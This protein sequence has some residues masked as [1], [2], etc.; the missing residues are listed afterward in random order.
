MVETPNFSLPLSKYSSVSA[1]S[2][3]S[4]N[5]TSPLQSAFS[6]TLWT[7][8]Q[9]YSEEVYKL[10]CAS[11]V[12]PLTLHELEQ[13]VFHS[14]QIVR[15]A[16][17]LMETQSA[18]RVEPI[19]NSVV[20]NVSDRIA[21]AS[22]TKPSASSSTTYA[23]NGIICP[24]K[25]A[26]VTI[27]SPLPKINSSSIVI[28]KPVHYSLFHSYQQRLSS[29]SLPEPAQSPPAST[30]CHIP[31]TV[32]STAV[33]SVEVIVTESA[34]ITN[35]DS[36]NSLVSNEKAK[37]SRKRKRGRRSLK[38]NL[39]CA[40]CKTTET[41][42]WRRGPNGPATL[43]N[44]CGIRWANKIKKER[45]SRL[46]HSIES[47]IHVSLNELSLATDRK[48]NSEAS[49]KSSSEPLSVSSESVDRKS[50]V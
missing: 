45:N 12:R 1:S 10:G 40:V 47:L 5:F 8:I 22:E 38:E 21:L 23:Q 15:H 49:M 50:V 35:S 41:P 48:H 34:N 36:G 24:T 33:N 28:P 11:K 16:K 37:N 7:K 19:Q 18:C 30:T 6:F 42:E 3:S 32:S 43:C 29:V 9:Y 13:V 4:S 2:M 14:I 17:S 46:K 25:T 31:Q 44:A 20:S 27:A 39:I 26:T